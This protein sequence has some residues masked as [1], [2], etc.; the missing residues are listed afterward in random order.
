MKVK[1]ASAI[2]DSGKLVGLAEVV[3]QVD[4]DSSLSSEP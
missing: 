1:I 2:T 3:K 4:G